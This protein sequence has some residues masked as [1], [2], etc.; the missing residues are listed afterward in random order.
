MLSFAAARAMVRKLKLGN[1]R[2][3]EAWRKTLKRPS[4]IPSNPHTVYRDD[5]WVSWPDW[6]ASC[7]CC[8]SAVR[9][10]GPVAAAS[11]AVPKVG[12]AAQLQGVTGASLAA[13][14]ALVQ[15]SVSRPTSARSARS[16]SRISAAASSS[17]SSSSSSS[18]ASPK[19]RTRSLRLATPQKTATA[20]TTDAGGHHRGGGRGGIDSCNERGGTGGRSGGQGGGGGRSGGRG[21]QR[22]W[23]QA[24]TRGRAPSRSATAPDSKKSK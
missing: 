24:T 16:S 10:R 5:G 19:K 12:P 13:I 1:T 7:S 2:Q 14:S 15:M 20:M 17:S 22:T 3:W 9:T 4:N 21:K 8:S 6:L 23:G 11:V 18:A